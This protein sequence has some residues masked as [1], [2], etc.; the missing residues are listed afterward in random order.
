MTSE[1]K[2]NGP[3]KTNWGAIDN[4]AIQLNVHRKSLISKRSNCLILP[5][6]SCT[7]TCGTFASAAALVPA[8]GSIVSADGTVAEV[9]LVSRGDCDA[10]A[11]T[12][13]PPESSNCVKS[14]RV[15]SIPSVVRVADSANVKRAVVG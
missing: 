11:D 4:G 9:L 3:L 2:S 7:K 15:S 1:T 13:R 14:T 12:F 10:M 6:T 8:M 5:S